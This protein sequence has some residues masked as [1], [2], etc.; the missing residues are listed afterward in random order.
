MYAEIRDSLN[1]KNIIIYI[2]KKPD[3]NNFIKINCKYINK[4]SNE[5]HCTVLGFYE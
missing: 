4:N 3:Y 5:M 2:I 1:F